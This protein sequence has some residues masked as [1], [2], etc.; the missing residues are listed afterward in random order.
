M[1]QARSRGLEISNRRVNHCSTK[2]YEYMFHS[3][4]FQPHWTYTD[5]ISPL[6]SQLTI[7]RAIHRALLTPP[8]Q[9]RLKWKPDSRTALVGAVTVTCNCRGRSAGFVPQPFDGRGQR[10]GQ[11]HCGVDLDR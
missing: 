8:A 2:T 4:H 6:N 9:C 10:P 5:P 7:G 3:W 11:I 1:N